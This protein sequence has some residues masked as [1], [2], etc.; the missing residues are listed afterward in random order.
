[1][2][3]RTCDLASQK[4]IVQFVERFNSGKFFI[5]FEN[6]YALFCDFTVGCSDE[7]LYQWGQAI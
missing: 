2:Y 1:V 7:V 6:C 4:S 3:C 5:V